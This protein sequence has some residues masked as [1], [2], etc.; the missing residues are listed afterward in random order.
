MGDAGKSPGR[1]LKIALAIVAIVA[2]AIA[3]LVG[4]GVSERGLPFV[5]ARIVA[6]TGGRISVEEP[7]GS[8]AG[9]M[10]FKRITWRGTDVTVTA[11][12]VVVDWNPG[13]LWRKRLSIHGLGARHVDIAIKPS[14]APTPPPTDLQLP[15]AVDIDRLDIGEL[16]WRTGP[17]AGHVSG[18]EFGYAGD[19]ELHRIRDLA[20]ISDYGRLH[21]NLAVGTRAP[22]AVAGTATLEGDGPLAGAR[23]DATL[24]G[25]LARIGISAKG[26]LRAAAL[27]LQAIATPFAQA[28][29][30]S[31][32]AELTG[33]D[34]AAL[35]ASLPHTQARM[36]L[37]FGPQGDGIA[38]M[39]DVVNDEP[40]PIDAA[41][42]PIAQVAARFALGK[43]SLQLDS[44]DATLAGGAGL[45][46]DGRIVLGT[47]N[48]A[49]HFTLTVTDVD[50][51]RLQTK[52]A[53]TRLSGRITAD[54]NAERQTIDGDVR[55]R[56]MTLAFAAAVAN[57]RIDVT[58]FRASTA[59]GSLE[60]SARM[61]LREPN[62]FT[63]QAK[64]QHLDPSRF[65]AVPGASLDGTVDASGVLRPRWRAG[66]RVALAPTS[67][68]A[69][70]ALSGNV[71]G[72]V[73]PGSVR[74]AAIDVALGSARLHAAGAAGTPGDRLTVTLDAPHLAEVASL[75]PASVPRPVAGELH[76]SGHVAIGNGI[77]GG[78]LEWRATALHAG[79]YA[80]GA[81]QGNASI[82]PP[83]VPGGTLATRALAFD[84]AATQL[85]LGARTLD[86][87][88]AHVTGSLA[89]HH[90][91]LAARGADFDATLALDGSLRN[92]DHPAEASWSGTLAAFENRG[93]IPA[94]LRGPAAFALHRDYAR[95]ADAHVEAADGRADIGEFVWDAGR[96]T[97]RGAFTGI[98]LKTAARLAGRTLPAESTLVLGGNWSIAAAPRLN[99]RFSLQR[100]RG[101]LIA[102]VPSGTST[103]REG[104][105]IS[106]L[107]IAGTFTEDALDAQA[108]FASTRAG[109]A[110]GTVSIGAVGGAASGKIDPAAS[111]RLSVRAELASLAVFQPW[112]G[113]EAAINGRAHLDV[114]AQGTV[115][116]PLW[117]GTVAGDGLVLDAPQ[118][119]VHVGDGR[120]RAHLA[121]SGIALDEAHFTGGDGTFDA[122]G[123]IALPGQGSATSRVTWKADR[124]RIT[125]RPDLRF[126]VNGNGSIALENRRLALHGSVAVA[127]GHVEYQPSPTGKLASDIVIEGEP[128]QARD[129]ERGRV[130]LT[131][132]VEVDLGRNLTFAGEG[133]ETELAG[134]VKI[135]TNASGRLEGRG[136]IRAVNGTYFAF[137]QKLT[138]DRGRLIF[139]GPLD[140]PALDVV[141][142]RKNLPVEA[143]VELSGTV[144]LPQVRITSNPPVPENE[145]LAW[146][147]T[148]QALNTTGRVD[149]SALS[150]ASAALL[151]RRGKPITADIAQRLGLTD[152]SLQSSGTGSGTSGAQGTASQVVVFGKR[153]SDR[154][155]LGYEQ[156]LSIASS[157]LRLEYALSRQITL[158][159]EA[160][161]VSGIGIVYRR[162]FR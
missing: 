26:T 91:T 31:A 50:L 58:R 22:L 37:A 106:A 49:A 88:H 41:R 144:K 4:Y 68:L 35:D 44:I 86:D 136:T 94:R 27:S 90:A 76:A 61:G 97:T 38:G 46:G 121:A 107:A 108:S 25:P 101:D 87:V 1:S 82:A 23:A 71:K 33:V 109:T 75:L 21:G 40:G 142:L 11:D 93:A 161:S 29:F 59:A 15:L 42:V 162:N 34:A 3:A 98:P 80:V 110:S 95:I 125:N 67:R 47:Q 9:T 147:V 111:L 72:T 140:N 57:E 69:G 81:T 2:I 64:M 131:L 155:S 48:R 45:R 36:H 70:V 139:D 30:A 12:D 159:A 115:G 73:A 114:A 55:D 60:G 92:V 19:A 52:L 6:Q 132:D 85:T 20:L 10:R 148:G 152:I 79:A 130:P 74:D 78:G 133:L 138:I 99:G 17:R 157:A 127:E 143:G 14:S 119:G 105:G 129:A 124:F 150:A 128:A 54:A 118:Y 149:Y 156:G 141:A 135:T 53:A 102:D 153:I 51:S 123:L 16:D 83:P 5:V 28:P 62:A 145:A 89:Q 160:G 77:I 8:I 112:F 113:T 63:V 7:T 116:H 43:E 104:V 126:V 66:A 39:L 151:G 117:T 137:G 84:I 154:L 96:I 120:L 103:R 134:R 56:D 13:A 65:A 32:T 122:T 18:L 100:E 24:E 146:L 158:R